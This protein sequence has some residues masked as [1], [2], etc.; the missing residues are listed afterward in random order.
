MH[1]AL[2]HVTSQLPCPWFGWGWSRRRQLRSCWR[3]TPDVRYCRKCARVGSKD[4]AHLEPATVEMTLQNNKRFLEDFHRALHGGCCVRRLF[5]CHSNAVQTTEL[6]FHWHCF[7]P[8]KIQIKGLWSKKP[9]IRSGLVIEIDSL[10]KVMLLLL[11]LFLLS[12]FVRFALNY[13][14]Q[15]QLERWNWRDLLQ[16]RR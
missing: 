11:L 9:L 10:Q 2:P 6:K 8:I 3:S 4:A 5:F 13:A 1:L 7:K 12:E 14:S 16:M 15:A